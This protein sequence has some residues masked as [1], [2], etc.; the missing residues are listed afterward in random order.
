MEKDLDRRENSSKRSMRQGRIV[1]LLI[2]LV[3]FFTSVMPS[4]LVSAEE[5]SDTKQ[6]EKDYKK[7]KK[8]Q[9]P[10][11][12]PKKEKG[13][14]KELKDRKTKGSKHFLNE[15]GSITAEI[16]SS[17]IHFKDKSGKWVEID[18]SI[19]NEKQ[20]EFEYGNK[21]NKHKLR[22]SKEAKKEVEW[23]GHVLTI[24]PLNTKGKRPKV[25][26]NSITYEKVFKDADIRYTSLT[27]GMKEDI[28]LHS[29]KAPHTYE[30]EVD[31][32]GLEV[33]KEKDGKITLTK[34]EETIFSIPSPFAYDN[35]GQVTT[36]ISVEMEEE[37]E[38]LILKYSLPEKWLSEEDR[39]FP[40]TI[41]PTV[42][43]DSEELGVNDTFV[44]DAEPTSDDFGGHGYLQV[45][46][47]TWGVNRA[48]VDFALPVLQSGAVIEKAEL[49]LENYDTEGDV[50]TVDIHQVIGKWSDT[51]LSWNTQPNYSQ[52]PAS[53]VNVGN[54]GQY[55]FDIT[56][57]TKQW[58]DGAEENYGVVVKH[59]DESVSGY[60]HFSSSE[61]VS[62]SP[63]KLMVTYK[64]QP[65]GSE[66]FW[67][68]DNNVNLLNG[69]YVDGGLDVY[70][71][72]RG[73]PISVSRTYNSHSNEEGI[74][75]HGWRLSDS[76]RIEAKDPLESR[77][78]KVT[79]P[80]G[81]VHHF[82][83]KGGEFKAPPGVFLDLSFDATAKT[84]EIKNKSNSV[85]G[86]NQSGYLTA[87]TDSNGNKTTYERNAAGN[88]VKMIDASGRYIDF[89]YEDG[90]HLTKI[91]GTDVTTVRYIYG[92]NGDLV[93][94]KKEN[95]SGDILTS[96]KYGY[97][98]NHNLTSITDEEGNATVISYTT[99]GKVQKFTQENV[100]FDSEQEVIQENVVVNGGFEE[101]VDQDGMP[102]GFNAPS[103][104][105]DLDKIDT[106]TSRAGENSFVIHNDS[107]INWVRKE[108]DSPGK[109]GDEFK[110]SAWSKSDGN[111]TGKYDV[112]FEYIKSDGSVVWETVAFD[113]TDQ[114]WHYREKTFTTN[115]DYVSYNVYARLGS[116]TGTAWFD[117]LSVNR[118]Y[119]DNLITN[120]SFEQGVDQDGIPDGFYAPS[121]ISAQDK[122]DTTQ[123]RSGGS[124]FVIHN[125]SE[126]N[127]IRQEY[128]ESGN[129]GDKFRLSAWSMS[130]GT[131]TG[132]YDV[133]F[134]YIKP[135]GSKEWEK[136]LFNGKDTTWHHREKTFTTKGDYDS[137][138][139]YVRL[140]QGEGMAWFDD[141]SLK[142]IPEENL[143]KNNS[144]ESDRDSDG[145]PDEFEIASTLSTSDGIDTTVAHTG[146]SSLVIHNDSEYN[147]VRQNYNISGQK[148][149]SFTLSGWSKSDGNV[150]GS[151]QV[152]FEYIDTNGTKQW[153]VLTFDGA[154]D[155]WHYREKEFVMGADYDNLNVY[156]RLAQGTG[157]AW[158]DDV[159]VKK[160]E[161]VNQ[162]ITTEYEYG[163]QADG[164]PSVIKTDSKGVQTRYILNDVGNLLEVQENISDANPLT[165]KYQW[166]QQNLLS[167]ITDPKQKNTVIY[168]GE[169]GNVREV[170]NPKQFRKTYTYDER[171][172][173]T[174]VTGYGGEVYRNFYDEKDNH[175]DSVTGSS[176]AS[177]KDYD[178][179][180]NLVSSTVPI[181][182]GNNLVRN[183]G[184]ED[185]SNGMPLH[186]QHDVLS[187]GLVSASSDSVEGKYSMK[188]QSNGSTDDVLLVSE[189]MEVKPKTKLNLSWAEKS[190]NLGS[191]EVRA[192]WFQDRNSSELDRNVLSYTNRDIDWSKK[193]A[194]MTVP[195]NANFVRI[196]IVLNTG[197]AWFDNFQLQ[198]A[199]RINS[200]NFVTNF[201]FE[202]DHNQDGSPDGW[203]PSLDVTANDGLDTSVGSKG[204]ETSVVLHGQGGN[205]YYQQDIDIA[206]NKG[207]KLTWGGF[208][209][210]LEVSDAG[211]NY[212]VLFRFMYSDGTTEQK[213][214]TFDSGTKDK[215]QY[216][217][218]SLVAGKDYK[219]FSVFVRLRGE[220]GTAWFDDVFV[221]R[222]MAQNAA[223]SEYNIIQNGSLEYTE[224][225]SNKPLYWEEFIETGKGGDGTWTADEGEAFIGEAGFRIVNP[226]GWVSLNTEDYAAVQSGEV[227]TAT[228]MAKTNANWDGDAYLK[229]NLYDSSKNKIK[230]LWSEKVSG[231]SDWTRIK[232]ELDVAYWKNTFP[233]LSYF[234]VGLIGRD[235]VDRNGTAYFD[236]VRVE[237]QSIETTFNYDLQGNYLESV[238]DPKGN[239][240][241][242]TVDNRGS[243][244]RIDFAKSG[245]YSE[246]EYDDLDRVKKTFNSSNLETRYTY[247]NVGNVIESRY[248]N[249]QTGY[250]LNSLKTNYNSFG[251]VI[252][253]IDQLQQSTNFYHDIDGS[254]SKV[255][256]PN[257]TTVNFGY[258][259][260]K[261]LVDV[262][263][264]G[265]TSPAWEFAYDTSGQL[266]QTTKNGS[267]KTSYK[268]DTD[269]TRI[270][271]VTY[272][273]VNGVRNT[274]DIGYDN[275]GAVTS[276]NHQVGSQTHGLAYQY[277][278]DGTPERMDNSNQGISSVNVFDEQGRPKRTI[279]TVGTADYAG[280]T[281]NVYI[282][283][284]E[285]GQVE[286]M[287]SENHSGDRTLHD[288]RFTYDELGNITEVKKYDGDEVVSSVVY[289]YDNAQRLKREV[290]YN[291]DGTKVSEVSY[292]F[293][294]FGNRL[295]MTKDG[296]TT[297]YEYDAANQLQSVD[298]VERIYDENGQTLSDGERNYTFNPE[299]SIQEVRTDS[300][301]LLGHYEY[302]Y[303]GKRNKKV[304]SDKTERYYY[305][306]G[307]LSYI[308]DENN[309]LK[310]SFTRNVGGVLIAMTDHT[311]TVDK[312]YYYELN[313]RGDVIGLFNTAGNKVVSYSYDSYGNILS[314]KGT[315]TTGNGKLLKDENPFRYAS[316]FYD[317]ETGLYYLNA[318]YYDAEIGRFLSRDSVPYLNL[319]AYVANNPLKLIDPSGMYM[320]HPDDVNK[321]GG[322]Y[323]H[324]DLG[325]MGKN[326]KSVLG[327]LEKET[328]PMNKV[329]TKSASIHEHNNGGTSYGA[330]IEP[331]AD[332]G[333]L[334][335][336]AGLNDVGLYK[337]ES[338]N[339]MIQTRIANAK[340]YWVTDF[341]Q[342]TV[343]DAAFMGSVYSA[344]FVPV[345]LGFFNVKAEGRV[346]SLGAEFKL[347]NQGIR[348]GA[349]ALYG[350]SVEITW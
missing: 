282:D 129:A 333:I 56:P 209:K 54:L 70:L 158:F 185:W 221:I 57:L 159:S 146:K 128:D 197:D 265:S 347:D 69:N 87:I 53:S 11:K 198:D 145:Y 99:D 191:M 319:Y 263:Y 12:F 37:G 47:N 218:N 291:G 139:V 328:R 66:D 290:N 173:V 40:V 338:E 73:I 340:T 245:V 310:Y 189:Y 91:V 181:S 204:S 85:Y 267:E 98:S 316:Y 5:S 323:H 228:A 103:T 138:N 216:K 219:G 268:Y 257:G 178:E 205:A 95:G 144:F 133:I 232:T 179:Y 217:E 255:K 137:Y 336:G 234:K 303:N 167:Q 196:Y 51:T 182:L 160:H 350:A 50:A 314:A 100:E 318:R 121:T 339:K 183:S 44:Y 264:N 295:T 224:Q 24:T 165:V 233:D 130:D 248:Y 276:F 172:N 192:L 186:W 148:G 72:G 141:I 116:G 110:L 180:G 278:E 188:L 42:T 21:A 309:N 253:K 212:D 9:L 345:D 62:E 26:G 28:I 342:G 277:F 242:Y 48:Y 36:G 226:E 329:P 132:N 2:V 341:T 162:T 76:Y 200:Y 150:T 114:S 31:T 64:V 127:W 68:Y 101:D 210:S 135:D 108:F 266:T 102:D 115:S 118:L 301:I 109:K 157:T 307:H 230:E 229:F 326:L 213:S 237:S 59:R 203:V 206:G 107:E 296:E 332:I 83:R 254:I 344:E 334:K 348:M 320:V 331:F 269:L 238:I 335:V 246:Q 261:Q 271:Q 279:N 311:G 125:D 272:P 327:Q 225:Y 43:L 187:T 294:E 39:E 176:S 259:D 7:E 177:M 123:S 131:V 193:T 155:S 211:G 315:T 202:S 256:Y 170:N 1:T 112:I 281:Y 163:V 75:G 324:P 152:I 190:S 174:Q 231:E 283:Y 27:S 15:D 151:Y 215:W 20:G 80:D 71:P 337:Y 4:N 322:R 313:H 302:N 124:S 251:E 117:S 97:D 94:V 249:H 274:L 45:G 3:M 55:K 312:N 13:K 241:S 49:S 184:L 29:K 82:S 74:L 297:N 293:D 105:S 270:T 306:N 84:Y 60:D 207:D 32:N 299:G 286:R 288:E 346:L 126:L 142:K 208:S 343:I 25:E 8:K 289:E 90:K 258:N 113:G 260:F 175:T 305:D 63:P 10:K 164:S 18:N 330:Y 122:V 304:T 285:L 38:V 93:E 252:E 298:G 195:E 92:A 201:D 280:Q 243:V 262:F 169:E 273:E 284:D 308:T 134:E 300:D 19:V 22:F 67:A 77:V 6:E 81:T 161:F 171:N 136:L 35:K 222:D 140:A 30:Y 33:N 275:S 86:F 199:S 65:L 227:Y 52:T 147:W 46:R 168:Y 34:G 214:A 194:S 325:E 154:D 250:F 61:R 149:D 166:D 236:A 287:W 143:L 240:T 349:S 23:E 41:D 17:P 220:T 223:V 120:G 247:D 153:E 106:S 96:V 89:L 58:Y 88:V 16:Y 104:I 244:K 78:V 239:T 111:V 317:E 156:L 321:H 79:D 292:T 119:T 14:K 235:D